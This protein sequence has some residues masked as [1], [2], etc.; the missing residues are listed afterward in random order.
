MKRRRMAR[1]LNISDPI[2]LPGQMIVEGSSVYT[3]GDNKIMISIL[4]AIDCYSTYAFGCVVEGFPTQQAIVHLVV[5]TIQPFLA[6]YHIR[7]AEFLTPDDDFYLDA[8][9]NTFETQLEA[10]KIAHFYYDPAN[11]QFTGQL[12]R[13]FDIL[14][15][16]LRGHHQREPIA[17]V[18]E[19]REEL[20]D[21]L[22]YW[23]TQRRYD[24]FNGKT[25]L[26]IIYSS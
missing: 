21:S 24:D 1:R 11:H 4:A 7:L 14:D 26:E 16:R 18:K 20:S 15:R 25:P 13:L 3:I 12:N 2:V 17:T 6:E 9:S 23:N 19:V 22:Q 5:N 8:L 10:M